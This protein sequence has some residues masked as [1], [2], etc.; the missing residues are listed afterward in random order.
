MVSNR[1]IENFI[2]NDIHE[3]HQDM[4][5]GMSLVLDEVNLLYSRMILHE[6]FE[7]LI[8]DSEAST[9]TGIFERIIKEVGINDELINDI[10]FMSENKIDRL[11][12]EQIPLPDYVFYQKVLKSDKVINHGGIIK[13]INEN[14]YLIIAKRVRKFT[15]GQIDGVLF[16]YINEDRL[17]ELY[18]NIPAELGYSFILADDSLVISHTK[19]DFVGAHLFD[20][21]FYQSKQFPCYTERMINNERSIIIVNESKAFNQRYQFNWKIVSVISYDALAK[22]I[23]QLNYIHIL[24]AIVMLVIAA[25]LAIKIS[26]V[27]TDPVKK[28]VYWLRVFTK[29]GKKGNSV[30]APYDELWELER[31]YEEMVEKITEL[32][33]KNQQEM[34]KQRKLELHTLQMQINPHFLYNTLDAIAWM[35]KIKKEKEIER[36]VLALAKFF[37]ISLHKGDKFI[38]VKEEIELIKNFIE[39]E[40]IRFPNKFTIEYHMAEG[41]E[42]K[43]TLKLILQPIVENAI[44][45]GIS[46]I[47]HLGKIVI[48]VYEEGEA[49]V[50]EVIDNGKGFEMTDKIFQKE[51]ENQLSGYGLK[52][53]DDRIKLEYGPEYGVEVTSEKSKGTK[54]TIRIESR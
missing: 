51:N 22:E 21:D 15:I 17:S 9:S 14:N 16:F 29:T 18:N 24:L 33:I 50:Y 43:E 52:N 11:T 19:G 4:Y 25:L 35:A 42:D 47:D 5:N 23:L 30:F 34:E 20:V 2:F 26:R 3:R 32:M 46:Q 41:V 44:K 13:D 38:K 45:H 12:E 39:I 31:T 49:I 28:I 7:Y 48:N 40:L 54:V 1:A 27:I 10:V 53:V 6:D 8:D 37:R 36:L